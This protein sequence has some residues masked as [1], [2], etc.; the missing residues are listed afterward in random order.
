[1]SY[2]FAPPHTPM[3][4]IYCMSYNPFCCP[5]TDDKYL[6]MSYQILCLCLSSLILVF[7]FL[8]TS[9]LTV[10]PCPP[11]PHLYTLLQCNALSWN[12][13]P[14]L[15][16]SPIP[17]SLKAQL[18]PHLLNKAFLTTPSFACTYSLSSFPP[19][20]N[21]LSISLLRV[22]SQLQGPYIQAH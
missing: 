14:F 18:K 7:Y 16:A 20:T 4:N 15:F 11:T 13:L 12:A 10:P 17:P 5:H 8:Q 19:L 22:L 1:M 6:C 2:P 9:P 21:K 3:M